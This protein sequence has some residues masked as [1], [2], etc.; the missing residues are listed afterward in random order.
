MRLRFESAVGRTRFLRTKVELMAFFVAVL[1]AIPS[2]LL[3]ALGCTPTRWANRHVA[4]MKIGSV[5]FAATAFVAAV[6]GAA[7]LPMTGLVDQTFRSGNAIPPFNFGVYFDSLT[8]VMLLLIS[9]IGVIV[10]R[11]SLRYLDGEA[12]QGRFLKW[13]SFTL[14]AVLM[15]VVSRSLAMFALAWIMTSFGLHQLLTH[16]A[17]RPRAIWVARE[18][19]LIS[20]LGDVFILGGLLLTWK[21]YGSLDYAVVFH[22]AELAGNAPLQSWMP[23]AISTLFVLGAMTK[24]A[25]FPFHCWLPDTMDTPTPVSALM[26]AGIINAGGFLIIRLSPLVSQSHLALD[27]LAL[28]GATTAL[29]GAVVMLTQP[30]IKRMLAFST[31]AQMG[32]MMLQCGLGA[33]SAALLHLVA[34]SL[35]KAHAFLSSGGVLKTPA[36]LSVDANRPG[37]S[38]ASTSQVLAALLIAAAL[39]FGARWLLGIDTATKAGSGIL[40]LVLTIA[41]LQLLGNSFRA[42]ALSLKLVGVCLA[43]GVTLSYYAAFLAMDAILATSVSHQT[44]PPSMLDQ[45]LTGVVAA[46]FVGI[47]LLQAALG[48]AREHRWLQALRIHAGNGFY[49]DVTARAITARVWRKPVP[50]E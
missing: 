46:G 5:G 32:F 20:R 19:F 21:C 45:V 40:G 22:A 31:V 13:M 14:G 41:L 39:P 15:L 7:L 18:K 8:A 3:L 1:A 17:N 30:S 2:L 24:S 34:H 42:P 49:F 25:Q 26:H 37:W 11:F 47:Y 50:I 23:A 33:F 29:L 12:T 4:V 36:G 16:Y 35:Y 9:F 48:R 27:F 6:A 10:M 43:A 38:L 28:V 44:V